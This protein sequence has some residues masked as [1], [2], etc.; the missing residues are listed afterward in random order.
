MVTI[1]RVHGPDTRL[2]P[3][4]L[5]CVLHY[6]RSACLLAMSP[7]SP[8]LFL[9]AFHFLLRHIYPTDLDVPMSLT[10]IFGFFISPSPLIFGLL[11]LMCDII[12]I[13]T[14]YTQLRATSFSTTN[15]WMALGRYTS[16]PVVCVAARRVHS[17]AFA[18]TVSAPASSPILFSSAS[19][20]LK[21]ALKKCNVGSEIIIT[22]RRCDVCDLLGLVACHF[23]SEHTIEDV[24]EWRKESISVRKATGDRPH[25]LDV[26]L[27]GF[28]IY[29]Y[30]PEV[31][32]FRMRVNH[33][34]EQRLAALR[35]AQLVFQL[36]KF[37][38]GLEIWA[39]NA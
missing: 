11:S 5:L 27:S 25:A 17:I 38:D 10:L 4:R 1:A 26:F 2:I 19:H 7:T 16:S 6:P 21:K 35:F 28:H 37:G 29:I 20:F 24:S 32:P 34:L 8:M 36:G 3:P 12:Y 13:L 39:V 9:Y 22:S 23:L 15:A 14:H 31:P 33:A 18:L 30:G